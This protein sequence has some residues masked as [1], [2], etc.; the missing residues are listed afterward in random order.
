[1]LSAA[2]VFM[3]IAWGSGGLDQVAVQGGWPPGLSLFDAVPLLDLCC[4]QRCGPA[5]AWCNGSGAV[6]HGRLTSLNTLLCALQDRVLN[7]TSMVLV[8][9]GSTNLDQAGHQAWSAT[10]N[11]RD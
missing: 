1:M 2:C 6:L 9:A 7:L 8:V 4:F 3:E 5:I 11:T 10:C